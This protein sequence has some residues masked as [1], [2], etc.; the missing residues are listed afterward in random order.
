MRLFGVAPTE[1]PILKI[2]QGKIFT[3]SAIP[4]GL[5]VIGASG[6]VDVLTAEKSASIVNR[7]NDPAIGK[8]HMYESQLSGV[9]LT[10]DTFI[11]FIGGR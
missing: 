11:K 9:P 10:R 5:W 4:I 7:S 2:Y 3:A 1:L 6:R 8:W